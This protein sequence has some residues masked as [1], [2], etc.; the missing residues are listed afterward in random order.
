MLF[1]Q[2]SGLHSYSKRDLNILGGDI[3]QGV[4]VTTSV[5]R[6]ES[7][8]TAQAAKHCIPITLQSEGS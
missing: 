2:L 8:Q 5:D 6:T 1:A 3:R 7:E 4:H